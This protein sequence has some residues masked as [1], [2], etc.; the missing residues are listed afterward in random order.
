M[1]VTSN[2]ALAR[3]PGNVLLR[4]NETGLPKDSVANLSQLVTIDTSALDSRVG[5]IARTKLQLLFAGLDVVLG[6]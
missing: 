1:S 6:R 4:A 5:V 2:V 3:A